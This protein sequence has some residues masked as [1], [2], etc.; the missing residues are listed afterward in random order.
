MC[1]TF[2]SVNL[3]RVRCY[4][5]SFFVVYPFSFDIFCASFQ[6]QSACLYNHA[7]NFSLFVFKN[8]KIYS[9]TYTLYNVH[10]YPIL[11]PHIL[12]CWKNEC[13]GKAA[14]KTIS[15]S[16]MQAALCDFVCVQRINGDAL[17]SGLLL[18]VLQTS[19]V[20]FDASFYIHFR[21]SYMIPALSK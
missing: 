15:E 9:F 3:F 14:N 8:V 4:W 13:R 19:Q 20:L 16:H 5:C 21:F 18:F 2:F 10:R 12:R 17:W 7:D 6:I 11:F 1:I